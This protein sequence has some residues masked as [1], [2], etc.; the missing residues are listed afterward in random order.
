MWQSNNHS[1]S[2]ILW[3]ISWCQ[4]ITK[5]GHFVLGTFCLWG[6]FV[7]WHFVFRHFVHGDILSFDILHMGTFYHVIKFLQLNNSYIGLFIMAFY[8]IILCYWGLL[9]IFY[10]VTSPL[11]LVVCRT[12]KHFISKRWQAFNEFLCLS[13]L[14]I[15]SCSSADTAYLLSKGYYFLTFVVYSIQYWP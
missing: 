15:S 5:R 8:Q 6:H 3:T 4:N 13:L 10:L 2:W 12:H 11:K 1:G 9:N 7:F 14:S